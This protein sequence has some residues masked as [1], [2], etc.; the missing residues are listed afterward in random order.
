MTFSSGILHGGALALLLAGSPAA[1]AAGT[2]ELVS[3]ANPGRLSDTA[4]GAQSQIVYPSPPALSAEGRWGAFLS[5]ANNLVGG[6]TG[7]PAKTGSDVF[8]QDRLSGATVLVSH[9]IASPA[10]TSGRG[11]ESAVLSADGRW[12]AFVSE[13]SDLVAGQSAGIFHSPHLFLF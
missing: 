2:V 11:A 6:Q 7:P 5:S 1:F 13:S 12:V 3:K 9:A 8:L 4:A 10:A